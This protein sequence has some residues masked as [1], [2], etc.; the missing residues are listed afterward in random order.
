MVGIFDSG[1]GGLMSLFEF[2]ELCP[3]VPAVFFADKENAPYG[4]KSEKELVRLV[5]DGIKKLMDMGASR[6]LMACCTASC[7]HGVLPESLRNYTIP[8]IEPTVEEALKLSKGGRIGVISTEATRRFG[9]FASTALRIE[10]TADV[11]SFSAP[12]LV[13]LAERRSTGALCDDDLRIIRNSV[14]PFLDKVDVLILGCT[15]FGYFEREIEDI[16]GC[17]TVNS[18]KIGARALMKRIECEC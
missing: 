15:H 6:V 11:L 2:R 4:E 5:S 13:T 3:S 12:E 1:V 14:L 7:V 16:L 18:A 8:I 10:P 17:P 9:A